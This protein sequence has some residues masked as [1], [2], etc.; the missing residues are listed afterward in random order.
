MFTPNDSFFNVL[1]SEGYILTGKTL[2]SNVRIIYTTRMI[3]YVK[4]NIQSLKEY[5]E[6]R[7]K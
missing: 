4:E 3:E 1:A 5:V 6:K 7:I 2:K